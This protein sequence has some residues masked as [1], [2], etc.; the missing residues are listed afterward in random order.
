MTKTI[1]IIS[2]GQTGVDMGA[3]DTA[4]DLGFPCG[5]WCPVGRVNEAGTIP[6]RYPL[7]EL[8]HGGY[9]ARTIRNLSE[10]DGTL[11]VYFGELEGGTEMTAAWCM[12]MRKPYRLIDGGEIPAERAAEVALAFV[13]EKRL[14]ALNVAGP[15]A[16]RRP[17]GHAYAKELVRGMLEMLSE[18]KYFERDDEKYTFD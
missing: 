14:M 4:L 15:R 10:A 7:K 2:G 11:I 13:Q 9:K 5:G 12:K 8:A 16:S 17:E 3:L 6:E 18:G 1:T